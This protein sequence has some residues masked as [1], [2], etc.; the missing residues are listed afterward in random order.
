MLC[1]IL[2]EWNRIIAYVEGIST[3]GDRARSRA[4]IVVIL[5]RQTPLGRDSRLCCLAFVPLVQDFGKPVLDV[6][7]LYHSVLVELRA[8]SDMLHH[9]Y[10]ILA[11]HIPIALLALLSHLRN[12]LAR[13][14]LVSRASLNL[15]IEE[16]EDCVFRHG[17]DDG[18]GN[19]DERTE[20]KGRREE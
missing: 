13:S 14:T 2:R 7:P 3:S 11:C 16:V 8:V 20:R 19:G 10:S 5:I 9:S 15:L 6:L 17:R 12:V 4:G 18:G 1:D